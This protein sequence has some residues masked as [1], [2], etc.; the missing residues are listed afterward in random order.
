MA[1]TEG[2]FAWNPAFRP[3]DNDSLATN[4]A[5]LALDPEKE[6]SE[7]A[8]IN[9]HVSPSAEEVARD[10]DISGSKSA[11]FADTPEQG[12]PEVVDS[13]SPPVG[14]DSSE[15][16]SEEPEERSRDESIPMQADE[17]RAA[18][19]FTESVPTENGNVDMTSGLR[20]E[21]HVAE[22]PHHEVP[23]EPSGLASQNDAQV[24]SEGGDAAWMDEA[25]GETNGATVNGEAGDARPG[26]WD[27][28]GDNERD[29]EDDFFT[30]LKTQ[31]KPIYSPP[32]TE[33]RFE[34][35]I[36]LLDHGAETQADHAQKGE[37][38]LDDVFGGNEDD[39]S[40]FFNEIQ[41]PTSDQGPFHITRKSTSQV[42][43]SL[44][45]GPDSPFSEQSPTAVGFNNSLAAPTA[46]DE[47]QKASSEDD[48]AAR[49][50]AELSDDADE[51]MPTE[52]DLAARWQAELDDDDDDLLLED[53]MTNAKGPEAANLDQM[54]E[55]GFAAILQS[56]FGTPE[57]PARPKVQPVSY[58]PHQ[59]STSDLLSGIP[60]QNTATQPTSASMS[61][62]F[63][64]QPPPNPVTTRAE[65]F[66]E[67]SKEGY[68]SPYDLPE[69]LARPRR[70]VATNRAVVAQPGTVQPQPPRSSSIPAP[71]LKASTVPPAPLGTSSAAPVPQ[72][73]FFEELPL[74]PP[75]PKSRPA[76]S[77]RYS[78]KAT[79][80]APSVP[81]SVPPPA[82]QYS[83]VP[84]APQSNIGPQ[85][86]P[87]LQQP[88]RLD[89]YSNLLAP[90]VP[91]A[92]AVPSAASRYSPRPPG[93]QAGV[94]PPHSPRY[95][96]A[97]PQSTTAAAAAPPRNRYA[98]QPSSISGQGAALQFQPRTSSPLAYH[99][100]VHYQDQGQ[101]EERPQLQPTASPPPW[102]H[103][104]PSEQPVVS[105]DKGPSGADVVAT[106]P[107]VS[108][109]PQ[110]PPKNPYAPSA[111]TSEFAKRPAPVSTGPPIAGMTGVLNSSSTEESPF[112]PPRRS[113]TQS[114][115]QTLSPRLSV[116][117]LD[118]FQR[119]ASVHG[120]TSPTRTVNPYAPAQVPIH[121]RAPSQVLEFIPPTDGQQLDSLERWKGAPIFRFGFG[122]AVI[123][124]FPKHIPRYSAG[125]AAPMIK[126]CPGEVRVSQLNDWLPAAE[127][128][129]Q[130][131]GP[132]KGKSKKKDLVAW[133][134]SKIA[135]FENAD[136]PDFDRLRPDA[137]KR[138][139]EKTLLWKIIRVLV[140]NDGVLEGSAEVQKSLR[141]LLFPDL[142]DQSLG[143]G[144]T[145]SAAF[146]PL[147]APSQ[148][149][150]IDPRSVDS[151]RDTLVLGEREKAVWAAVDNR[152]WGHAMIIASTMDR[153]VWQQVVQEFVR[154]EVRS[155]TSRTESL[156]A[157]YEILAGNVEESIDELVPPSARAGLQMISKVD[158]HGPAKDAL[159]GLDSWRE[160][161]GLV[162]SNRSPNDQQA[163]VA[164]GRLLLTY[165]RTEA[166]HICF[167]LSRAA[168]FGGVDDPLAN[169]VLLGVDHQRLASSAALYDDD[170]IL[171]TEAY[172]F[173]TS[174]LA[175]LP[176]ATLPHLL[177]FKLIHAWSLADR[178]RKSEAQQYCDA[179][180]AALKA[181]TKPSGYHNQHLFLGVDELSARLRETTSDGGSSWIS[182]PSMEKVSGSMWAKFNSFVAGD[183]SDAASTGSG[184]AD[185][186]GPFARVSGTPTISRSP[187]VSDIYGS[188]PVAAAQPLPGAGPSRYQPVSHYAPSASPEQ[189]R[190]RSSMDSQRSASFGYPIGQRRGSQDPSTPVD[191]N[192]YHGMPLYGSPPVAGYQS[193]PPQSS[194]MPLAPVAEDSASGAQRGS[195]SD[196]VPSHRPPMYAPES[197]GQPLD[198][199]G[200]STTSQPDQGGYMP[201]ASTGGYEPPAVESNT[202]PA[203]GDVKDESTEEA[204]PKKKSFMDEDDDDDLAARVAAIQKAERARRDREADE[205]FRKAAEADAQKPP[206]AA[207]KKGWFSGWFGGK[208]DDTSGGGPIRAKLGEENSFYY[209]KELKKWVNKKDPGSAAPTRGTPPPPKASAAPSRTMSGSGGP[210]AMATPP[211]TVGSG[212]PPSSSAGAPPSV[213]ASPAPPSLGAPP[214][215]IPR[216]VS[217]GAVLPT[218]PGSSSGA[219]PRPATSLSNA[220]SI[221]DLLGAPQARKGPAAR[222]KKKGRYVDVMA[223]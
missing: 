116:P 27:N 5:Q 36:P 211:Q 137:S 216:S 3:E 91:G 34:E 154:R 126:S 54:N 217:T 148:P 182:R 80:S 64:A 26:F 49:W 183:D 17:P 173:A 184:K 181:T 203:S 153:S 222:G 87:Q 43:N 103:S 117:S 50:Q 180:A 132:L 44:N 157:F 76:S 10:N 169:I 138:R 149:D 205:A 101:S 105:E 172:E 31:T 19:D 144:F 12:V 208:K 83:N 72:K 156:A 164:L 40:G 71:P 92:P 2:V 18:E 14:D 175:G 199:R 134:S 195:V 123:S 41:K 113:Q 186:I 136:I 129:V 58:T 53:D 7:P 52:D 122:G 121:N 142:Q 66:A 22:G 62:Y 75:R 115:S 59:P 155:A 140:E 130:H 218:P 120:S 190:G 1:Q 146:Q 42:M 95:S 51:T 215:A 104:H 135:A 185:E 189:L 85:N 200:A 93:L 167:I 197:F 108:T 55:T 171:L 74:P 89:P 139:E 152:L 145:P 48:L 191:T 179:I 201:P 163:L 57:N 188:Y 192:M 158:G 151:L 111:Y 6:V 147:N 196:S 114:P 30:Q 223:K 69:D 166:A 94:K 77:G 35:G 128:I 63:S 159:E 202:E 206:P 178:G 220:S 25:E 47:I 70:V 90:T 24:L 28:L 8:D 198:T 141:N 109:Q 177:A 88:E 112:V 67:R 82:N 131:P 118:P 170:A 162:L 107:P 38:Q 125:Q 210:P 20:L 65:S 13:D 187:S 68:K 23:E 110:S 100:K 21:E 56:P 60:A 11:I 176:M 61:N 119:P 143:D 33:S 4:L 165:N 161:L 78:P 133:L 194:Y 207:G 124:C 81:Q 212:S 16:D 86:P 127:S 79:V 150:A 84:P 168:V 39:E 73:N 106:M 213:S 96:P 9:I 45:A 98:S 160:T 15:A 174:V 193:T 102:N 32:E 37:D 209:D 97:P 29:D 99:E 214:S 221:D 46:E 219:P 204:K